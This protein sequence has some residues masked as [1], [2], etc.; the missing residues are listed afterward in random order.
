MTFWKSTPRAA[1][2]LK[3]WITNCWNFTSTRLAATCAQGDFT[4]FW[5]S[6]SVLAFYFFSLHFFIFSSVAY[7]LPRGSAGRKIA[8]SHFIGLLIYCSAAGGGDGVTTLI[9]L[10]VTVNALPALQIV[11][12][13]LI[14]MG[15]VRGAPQPPWLILPAMAVGHLHAISQEV[16][17]CNMKPSSH[18]T[19]SSSSY[20][21][22]KKHHVLTILPLYR[23][24]YSLLTAIRSAAVACQQK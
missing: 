13:V 19:T 23:V 20:A 8:T 18:A 5:I 4:P 12:C 7:Y 16:S 15:K 1:H 21:N 24:I 3:G 9:P 22:P 14:W 6:G 10:T 2:H 11:S 17:R